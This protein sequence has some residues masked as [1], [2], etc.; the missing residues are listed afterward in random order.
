MGNI[1]Y[2]CNE[3]CT[4]CVVPSV[5]GKEQSRTP[6]AIKSEIEDLA[7]SGYKETTLL[8]Q[9]IDAYGRDFQSQHQGDSARITLSY[10]LKYE[11]IFLMQ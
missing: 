4:Y 6:E 8:G 9:N 3:R 1:I 7:K 2:G 10:L 5:R 11:R